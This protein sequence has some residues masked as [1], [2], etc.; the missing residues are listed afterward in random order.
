M[1]V[2]QA[3]D[4]LTLRLVE[5]GY[6]ESDP[7]LV[8]ALTAAARKTEAEHKAR[9]EQCRRE[10]KR[11]YGRYMRSVMEDYEKRGQKRTVARKARAGVDERCGYKWCK[12]CEEMLMGGERFCPHCGSRLIWP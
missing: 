12:R 8:Q 5:L 1:K 4:E 11:A 2:T 10:T 3:V 6:E 9:M 7:M